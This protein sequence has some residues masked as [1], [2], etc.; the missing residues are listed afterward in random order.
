MFEDEE[1]ADPL[2]ASELARPDDEEAAED[3]EFANDADEL[4]VGE[5]VEDEEAFIWSA[6][7]P[8]EDEDDDAL[9]QLERP[10]PTAAIDSTSELK[11]G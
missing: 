2:P 5:V 4:V 8:F 11:S 6:A 10:L 1:E 3:E 9:D 7:E